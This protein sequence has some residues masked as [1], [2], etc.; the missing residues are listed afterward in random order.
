M[1]TGKTTLAAQVWGD[2]D[3]L[4]PRGNVAILYCNQA[5]RDAQTAESFLGSILI[6]LYQRLG[7]GSL[8]PDGV[9]KQFEKQQLYLWETRPSLQVLRSWLL[10]RLEDHRP[11]FLVI[12]AVDKLHD[13]ARHQPLQTLQGLQS[14]G[15]NILATSR[16]NQQ[17]G[18]G[19]EIVIKASDED[20]Y[21]VI[22]SRLSQAGLAKG[23]PLITREFAGMVDDISIILIDSAKQRCVGSRKQWYYILTSAASFSQ[24]SFSTRSSF[25]PGLKMSF[26]SSIP[27]HQ[28]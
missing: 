20:L 22:R 1:G 4:H 9:K 7:Q 5:E 3:A 14:A 11:V 27:C 19:H 6:Q 10:E 26:S 13:M 16:N 12:D 28:K 21:T 18:F 23:D 17:A 15:L 24:Q 2:L 8:I 25:A